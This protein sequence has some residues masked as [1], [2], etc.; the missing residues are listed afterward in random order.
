[1]ETKIY[2]SISLDEFKKI[3][4]DAIKEAGDKIPLKVPDEELIS[5]KETAKILGVS[6]PTLWDWSNKG[7]IPSYKIGSKVM[8]KKSE[9]FSSVAKV[10][11]KPFTS[12]GK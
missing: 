5:R 8:Y 12:C 7:V 3:I 10:K 9:V 11:F 4:S 1:M 2:F 6:L